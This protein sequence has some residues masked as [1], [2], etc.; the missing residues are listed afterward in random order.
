MHEY[1]IRLP[2]QQELTI[3]HYI[4]RRSTKDATAKPYGVGTG[5]ARLDEIDTL[6][7]E[8]IGLEVV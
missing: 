2:S 6:S 4:S 5:T 8:I 1:L 7:R 3:K